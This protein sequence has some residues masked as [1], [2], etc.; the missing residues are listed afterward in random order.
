MR[1][2]FRAQDVLVVGQADAVASGRCERPYALDQRDY[3]KQRVAAALADETFVAVERRE[4]GLVA[5]QA[6]RFE[7]A[8]GLLLMS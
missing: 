4:V 2:Q 3:A 7:V 1:Y 8:H 6:A 5:R